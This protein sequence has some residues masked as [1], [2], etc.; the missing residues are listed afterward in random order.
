MIATTFMD[1][2][3][4]VL[5]CARSEPDT[6]VTSTDGTR[7]AAFVTAD[8]R[9]P[10]QVAAVV[11]HEMAHVTMRHGLQRIGQA[12]GLM[13][14]TQVLLGD[15]HGLFGAGADLLTIWTGEESFKKT[16]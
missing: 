8:V 15:A 10:D 3:A 5:T 12:I 6:L 9:D 7:E 11:A 14:A 2:G 4:D 16:G 13:V 1:A